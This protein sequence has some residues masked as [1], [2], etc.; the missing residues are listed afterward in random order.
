MTNS[1]LEIT[2]QEYT[3]KLNKSDFDLSF[4]SSLIKRIQNEQTFF[5]RIWEDDGD[6]ISKRSFQDEDGFDHLSEK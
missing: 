5:S 4:I 3:L 1:I 6:I 2:D